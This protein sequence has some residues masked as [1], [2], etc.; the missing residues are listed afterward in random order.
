LAGQKTVPFV[1]TRN[2]KN[3]MAGKSSSLKEN[4][5]CNTKRSIGQGFKNDFEL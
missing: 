1:T 5:D 2:Y 3:K 4:F